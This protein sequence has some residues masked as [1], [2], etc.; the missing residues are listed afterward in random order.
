MGVWSAKPTDVR[1]P[2]AQVAYGRSGF[3]KVDEVRGH[4]RTPQVLDVIAGGW[5]DIIMVHLP[6]Y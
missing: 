5:F 1:L 4:P 6:L 2:V 3:P